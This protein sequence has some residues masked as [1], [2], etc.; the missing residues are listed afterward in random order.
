MRE[1]T[2]K[3]ITAENKKSLFFCESGV[4][5]QDLHTNKNTSTNKH[6]HIY[7]RMQIHIR[8]HMHTR[9]CVQVFEDFCQFLGLHVMPLLRLTQVVRLVVHAGGERGLAGS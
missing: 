5:T 2:I 4:R 9:A 1:G 6:E 8:T 7:T 3:P